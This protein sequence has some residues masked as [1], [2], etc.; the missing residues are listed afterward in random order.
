DRQVPPR[1]VALAAHEGTQAHRE[2][3][4]ASR[5]RPGEDR[6]LAPRRAEDARARPESAPQATVALHPSFRR[7]LERSGPTVLRRPADG[8]QLPAHLRRRTAGPQGDG[9]SL[10]TARAN[11]GCRASARKRQGLLSLAEPRAL[12][13][14]PLSGELRPQELVDHLRI[15]LALGLLH[16]LAHEETEQ[17][18]LPT[19]VSR[20]LARV[21]REDAFDERLE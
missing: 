4:G 1:D 15:G 8:S 19:F 14:S 13:R 2:P 20:N 10:D 18:V 9:E 7:R 5:D 16:H 11:V 17:A 3:P 6:P 21:G 12:L